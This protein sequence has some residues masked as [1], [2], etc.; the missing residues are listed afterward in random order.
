[1]LPPDRRQRCTA[2]MSTATAWPV[3]YTHLDVYKRQITGCVMLVGLLIWGVASAVLPQSR[4][5][6]D[7]SLNG[8]EANRA[9]R[10]A[11]ELYKSLASILW[12]VQAFLPSRL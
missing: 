6:S 9:E 4:E 10:E 8:Y 1:M 5:Y 3:S 2:S 11:A 7:S 12:L